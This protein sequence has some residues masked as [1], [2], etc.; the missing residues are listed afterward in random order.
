[1]KTK[2]LLVVVSMIVGVMTS[3]AQTYSVNAVGYV[4]K[5]IPAKGL[6]LL[7]NPL[8]DST[9]TIKKIFGSQV[10]NGLTIYAWDTTTKS[11]KVGFYDSEFGW[12]PQEIAN[13]NLLPGSGVFIKNPSDKP[14]TVTFVGEVPQGNLHTPLVAG[15]QIVS[16]Q[17]PRSDT[18]DNLGYV[19]E[20]GDIVYQW[21]LVNQQYVVAMFDFE[22]GW[23]PPL[24]VLEIG[25]AFFLSRQS[26][27]SWDKTFNVNQ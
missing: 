3:H 6:A 25:D 24:K 22:F 8:I 18:I 21:D 15:L 14:L 19:P 17:V 16:S 1:M 26:A 10:V 2:I 4:N 5:T 7:S 9:N 27:G 13:L 20:N 23:D 12:E 11:Y